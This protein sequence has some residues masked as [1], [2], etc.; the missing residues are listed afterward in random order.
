MFGKNSRS[1]LDSPRPS[2]QEG[3]GAGREAGREEGVSRECDGVGKYLTCGQYQIQQTFLLTQTP[4]RQQQ[5]NSRYWNMTEDTTREARD[6]NS[7]GDQR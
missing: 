4:A 7:G 6:L 1:W 2:E 5:N 3:V